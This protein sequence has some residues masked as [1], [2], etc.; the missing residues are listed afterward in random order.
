[1]VDGKTNHDDASV[2][3]L[4]TISQLLSTKLASVIGLAPIRLCL[5]GRVRGLLCIHGLEIHHKTGVT[6]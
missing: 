6:K 1:M 5:K 2:S 3:P 4:S